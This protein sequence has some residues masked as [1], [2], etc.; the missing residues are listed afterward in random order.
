MHGTGNDFV[1]VDGRESGVM[2]LFKTDS[3]GRCSF[4]AELGH[5]RFGLGFDQL[6]LIDHPT[7]NTKADVFMRI[8]NAD[9]SVAEMCGNGV[10]CAAFYV[11]HLASQTLLKDS[12]QVETLSRIVTVTMLT[13]VRRDP[14]E[15]N[16]VSLISS[17][18]NVRVDMGFPDLLSSSLSVSSLDTSFTG[19]SISMGNP[20]FI[21]FLSDQ[22][23]ANVRLS[24]LDSFPVSSH[25]PNIETMTQTFPNKTNVEFVTATSTH[26]DAVRMRVWERGAGETLSCGSGACAVGAASLLRLITLNKPIDNHTIDVL[27]PGGM[28]TIEW[29]PELDPS[30]QALH[31]LFM[32]G[33]AA[34]V[35]KAEIEVFLPN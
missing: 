12:F 20:H 24:S 31:P 34:L 2:T 22:K 33:P 23:D 10:R 28:L 26:F 17:F 1:V 11:R 9:G 16:S 29:N 3:S 13:G 21:I 30:G 4:A 6:L 7:D 32:T 19:Y 15:A 18:L 27:L 25:G 14:Q 35:G 5:R 8:F